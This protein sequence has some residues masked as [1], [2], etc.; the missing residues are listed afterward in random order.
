MHDLISAKPDTA[1]PWLSDRTLSMAD[2]SGR[3]ERDPELPATRRRDLISAVRSFCRQLKLD[4]ATTPA[5]HAYFRRHVQK[6]HHLNSG[7]SKK[8]FQNTRALV[9]SAL[10]QYVILETH[11]GSKGLTPEWQCLLGSA[12]RKTRPHVWHVP[13]NALLQRTRD[14]TCGRF[15]CG[16]GELSR[17]APG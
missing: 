13:S 7:K 11:F 1:L 15:G 12:S 3:I 6:F 10:R 9:S 5:T 17:L 16:C 14:C 2:L 4:P 8:T